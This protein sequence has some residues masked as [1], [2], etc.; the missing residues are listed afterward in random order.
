MNQRPARFTLNRLRWAVSAALLGYS[1]PA[2]SDAVVPLPGQAVLSEQQGVPALEIVAP[3]ARGVSHNSFSDYNVGPQGLVLNNSL[4]AGQAQLGPTLEA[5]RH[6][7]GHAASAIVLEVSGVS[8]SH[9][10][11]A[12]EIFGQRADYLLA[13]PNGISLNGASFINANR[14]SFLV[15]IPE[16]EDGQIVR[17]NASHERGVMTIGE[18]GASNP[19]GALELITPVLDVEGGLSARD[20][21]DIMLGRNTVAA[22]DR[23]VLSTSANTGA[24]VDARL[25]GAMRGG[26]ISI[27]STADGAGVKIPS[28][29]LE[30]RDGVNIQAR[31][32]LEI[33]GDRSRNGVIRATAGEVRLDTN[34]D[35]RATAVDISGTGITATAG[36]TLRLDTL[37]RERITQEHEQSN[38]KAWFIPTEEYSKRTTKTNNEH[39]AT[40]L[41]SDGNI[42]LQAGGDMRLLAATVQ[43]TGQLRIETGAQLHIDAATDNEEVF[44][45]VRHRKHLWR[46]DSNTTTVTETARGSELTGATV[47]IDSVGDVA[48]RGSRLHSQGE[49]TLRTAGQVSLDSVPVAYS[50]QQQDFRGDL[51]GGHLFGNTVNDRQRSARQRGSDFSAQSNLRIEA[52]DKAVLV[53]SRASAGGTLA[54]DAKAG[55]ELLPAVDSTERDTR[56]RSQG[57]KV[58]VGETRAAA[59]GKDGSKQYH[60]DVGYAVDQRH[61]QTTASTSVG[62]QLNGDTVTVDSDTRVLMKGASVTSQTRT[63]I[64]APDVNLLASQNSATD[65]DQQ[66]TTDGTLR[67][68]GGMDR[69]GSAFTG[70]Y[71][72]RADESADT[73]HTPTTLDSQGDQ[74]LKGSTL[75]NDGS[76]IASKGLTRQT[77]DSISQRAVHDQHQ[78][79]QATGNSRGLLAGTLEYTDITR[80]IEKVVKG[81]EQSRFQQQGVEDNLFAPSLGADLIVEHQQRDTSLTRETAQVPRVTGA[82]VEVNATDTLLDIGT[83]YQASAGEVQI[84]AGRHDQ[85]ASFNREVNTL[86]RLDAD[87]RLRV[88]TNTG[89]DINAKVVGSGSSLHTSRDTATAVPSLIDGRAGIQVQLGSDGRY[90]GSQWRSGG[91]MQ[92][93]GGGA[94]DFTAAH[95]R[96][97]EQQRHIDGAAWAKGGTSPVPGKTLGGSAI[98]S[99]Q[100][101]DSDDRQARP[102]AFDTPA[103][104]NIE[105]GKALRLQAPRMGSV[106]QPVASLTLDAGGK[107][108]VDSAHDSHRA[109]GRTYGGG[110][111]ASVSLNGSAGGLG[112]SLQLAQV[113]ETS[114]LAKGGEWHIGRAARV[115]SASSDSAA[116]D[117]QGLNVNADT[118]ALNSSKGGIVVRGATSSEQRNNKAVGV[119]LAVNGAAT[120]DAAKGYSAVHGRATLNLDKLDSSTHANSQVK[121]DRLQLDSRGDAH[122]SSVK[123]DAEQ[124]NG[125]VAG[126]LVVASQ[127]DRVNG[128][129]VD[130]DGRLNA[131]KN[132]QGLLNGASALAGPVAGKV[133]ETVGGALQKADPGIAPT[134][135]LDVSKQQRDTASAQTLL[136]GRDGIALNVEGD[137]RLEGALLKSAK[138]TVDLGGSSVSTSSQSG[139]DHLFGFEGKVSLVPEEMTQN[140]INAFTG[141]PDRTDQTSDLGLIRTKGHDRQQTLQGGIKHKEG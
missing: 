35:L 82:Q 52:T 60:A 1:L 136:N 107:V 51:V 104:V 120:T 47:S 16:L 53:G 90:E 108:Q 32:A 71:V 99:Y 41:E 40:R 67:V 28:A 134:L 3:N 10:Q 110:A 129:K 140:L 80:P 21:L 76:V 5:N 38:H 123:I 141:T 61:Q 109:T 70:G 58:A 84:N 6:F 101:G 75:S 105:A 29:L 118:L 113:D 117:L 24:P 111:Q 14:A 15:G 18:G 95:D 130:L 46:G 98:G 112:G 64:N 114:D 49:G 31:G 34:D 8:P 125:T 135:H 102:V 13:N 17:L 139:T 89:T 54:L 2:L 56:T 45:T 65:K 33:S 50:Q 30:G 48:I 132:P 81:D 94:L 106:E 128:Y 36:K 137:T 42:Y 92:I 116:V 66:S 7:Q 63:E 138:G 68:T 119:G 86:N 83:R 25:L 43:A 27:I 78:Q 126:D 55:V 74:Y 73:T 37:T 20:D 122:L 88:D 26:R 62:S 133:K 124:I 77:F 91:A 115:T 103:A 121:V 97:V 12:Q 96:Q 85:Q 127:Q 23:V 19:D 72:T 59:D 93:N 9:I 22:A 131:E 11:G 44:E 79:R 4:H 57:F 100:H 39:R 69:V 87:T